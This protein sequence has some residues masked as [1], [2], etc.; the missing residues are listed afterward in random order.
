M[1]FQRS[2]EIIREPLQSV[3]PDVRQRAAP[4][5]RYMVLDSEGNVVLAGTATPSENATFQ[6][7]FAGKLAAG[8][9]TMLAQITVNGN[10]MNADIQRIPVHVAPVP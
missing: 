6:M 4:Q 5:C 7:V 2:Y 3:S 8:S 1:K 9:Y 10:A